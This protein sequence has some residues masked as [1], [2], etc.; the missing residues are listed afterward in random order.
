MPCTVACIHEK[1]IRYGKKKKVGK[2][3]LYEIQETQ[4]KYKKKEKD[5]GG[6]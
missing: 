1:F 3:S 6:K 2:K 4:K 5:K